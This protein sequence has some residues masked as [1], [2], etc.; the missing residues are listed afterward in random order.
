MLLPTGAFA[1]IWLLARVVVNAVAK[2]VAV[3]APVAAIKNWLE[4]VNVPAVPG[5]EIWILIVK[6]LTSNTVIW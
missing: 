3:N 6:L 5:V 2:F 4:Q 1:V